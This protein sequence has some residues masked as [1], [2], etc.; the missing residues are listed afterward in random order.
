MTFL[1]RSTRD[2]F[3]FNFERQT[4]VYLSNLNDYRSNL[5]L[6]PPSLKQWYQWPHKK[7]WCPQKVKKTK[8][9]KLTYTC[10]C[11][12]FM[13]LLAAL[14]GDVARL[15]PWGDGGC[16]PSLPQDGPCPAADPLIPAASFLISTAATMLISPGDPASISRLS[17]SR[18]MSEY[19]CVE[20][21]SEMVSIRKTSIANKVNVSEFSNNYQINC[22][23]LWIFTESFRC[24]HFEVLI[25][26]LSKCK[27]L[28][29][30][31]K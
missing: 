25:S 23:V 9:T 6:K 3:H 22:F 27:L 15:E 5:D 28:Q 13:L 21:K 17:P 4:N 2:W 31:T 29:S 1:S 14:D 10:G 7:D 24:D 16:S 11:G 18:S 8:Q 30:P 26:Q 20:L 12:L 19:S